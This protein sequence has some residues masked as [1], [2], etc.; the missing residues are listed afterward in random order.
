MNGTLIKLVFS[1]VKLREGLSPIDG[2]R[3]TVLE[4]WVVKPFC[5]ASM[6]VNKSV[7]TEVPEGNYFHCVSRDTTVGLFI[8]TPS[9]SG[10]T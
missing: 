10:T 9:K 8:C 5:A 6:L 4:R 3:V 1:Y 7:C 2:F